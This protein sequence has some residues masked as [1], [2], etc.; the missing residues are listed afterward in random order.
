MPVYEKKTNPEVT[1]M[2]Q[3]IMDNL[4]NAL[5]NLLTQVHAVCKH[6]SC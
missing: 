6:K 5:W 2:E 4:T 3:Q 1:G